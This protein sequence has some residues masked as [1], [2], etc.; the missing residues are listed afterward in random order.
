[1]TELS[2]EV[3]ALEYNPTAGEFREIQVVS[4]I[5]DDFTDNS[6]EAQFMSR[7]TDVLFMSQTAAMTVSPYLK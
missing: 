6:Q 4:A 7:R 3:I 5:P 1:M 2:N